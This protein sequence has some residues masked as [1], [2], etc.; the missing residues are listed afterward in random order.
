[1]SSQVRQVLDQALRLPVDERA[2]VVAELLR[3]L[4]DDEVALSPDEVEQ[5]WADE[6]AR[7]ADQVRR[8]ESAG[9]DAN[10]VLI[11]AKLVR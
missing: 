5:R 3:S 11:I 9:R 6:I 2:D 8:G 4:D 10:E 1:M 7:R